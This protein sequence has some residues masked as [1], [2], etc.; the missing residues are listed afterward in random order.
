MPNSEVTGAPLIG[1][2]MPPTLTAPLSPR[3]GGKGGRG[4]ALPP[5]GSKQRNSP[6]VDFE[7]VTVESARADP[8]RPM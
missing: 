4:V 1:A 8:A 7:G 5:L 3:L 6:S 2:R